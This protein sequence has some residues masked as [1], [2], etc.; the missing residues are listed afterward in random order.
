MS[1]DNK[2]FSK[3]S[4]ED[5][6]ALILAGYNKIDHES[7]KVRKKEIIEAY[8]GDEIYL[9]QNKF[10]KKLAGKPVIQYVLDAVYN[11]KKKDGSPL[12]SKIFVYNDVNSFKNA[13]S[14]ENYNNLILK[15]M[16][17]SVGGHWKDFYFNDI[18]YGQ[19]V[20]VFFGDTPRIK[21]EDVEHVSGEFSKIL[22]KEKDHRGVP[23]SML[24]GVVEAEDLSD[25]WL[26]QRTKVIKR[27]QYKGK[28]K[29]FVNFETRQV[30]VGNN[31]AIIKVAGLDELMDKECVNFIYNLRKALTPS[32]ISKIM[33]YLWKLKKIKMITQIKNKQI[34]EMDFID[35]VIDVITKLYKIDLSQFAGKNVA[36]KKHAGRW[37]NDIDGPKDFEIFKE[38][39]ERTKV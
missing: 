18:D 34:N 25:S 33:Y 36:L 6:Y 39:F 19:R 35:T 24:F 29:N 15:Q 22:L 21:S 7:R 26:L 2:N 27:G 31:G 9:G 10:L 37:E 11:A 12:Y 28:L 3:K 17:D 13:I 4:S 16:T 5:F 23:I 14:V 1:L 32:S 20:D 30:R 8:D 38:K